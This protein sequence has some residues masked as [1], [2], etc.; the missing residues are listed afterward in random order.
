MFRIEVTIVG[1]LVAS[2][3][4]SSIWSLARMIWRL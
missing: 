3:A 2:G 1:L 4:I